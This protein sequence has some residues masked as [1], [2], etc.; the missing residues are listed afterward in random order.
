MV[1]TLLI[2]KIYSLENIIFLYFLLFYNNDTDYDVHY[3]TSQHRIFYFFK[4]DLLL[5]YFRLTRGLLWTYFYF[6]S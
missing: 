1:W 2:I 4:K 6:F 3:F 5:A